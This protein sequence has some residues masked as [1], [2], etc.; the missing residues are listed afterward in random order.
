MYT[1]IDTDFKWS[2][3]NLP[4]SCGDSAQSVKLADR[5]TQRAREQRH[6]RRRHLTPVP[7]A[8]ATHVDV[9]DSDDGSPSL[10]ALSTGVI[11]AIGGVYSDLLYSDTPSKCPTTTFAKRRSRKYSI[12]YPLAPDSSPMRYPVSYF[13][14]K[15]GVPSNVVI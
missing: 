10:F 1:R 5:H 3:S 11:G 8:P 14:W 9:T 7:P 2:L 4:P 13:V 12:R 15:S 6:K